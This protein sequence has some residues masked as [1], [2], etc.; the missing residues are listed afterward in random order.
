MDSRKQ[1]NLLDAPDGVPQS[2]QDAAQVLDAADMRR[3][4]D[5]R[6]IGLSDHG[7]KNDPADVISDD[8]PDLID[9]MEDM[10]H[11]GHIDEDAYD[12]EP[13]HDDA[14]GPFGDASHSLDGDEPLP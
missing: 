7:R 3:S 10:V 11:S 6:P 13:I 12:G 8:V 14:E 2:Q 1:P 4:S 9:R 5:M